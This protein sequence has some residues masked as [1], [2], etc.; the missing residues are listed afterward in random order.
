MKNIKIKKAMLQGHSLS[1]EYE[2]II[3]DGTAPV[4]NLHKS[5]MGMLCHEDLVHAFNRLKF[6]FALLC[7]F[8]EV[9]AVEEQILDLDRFDFG[10]SLD[11]VF[12]T[13][14]HIS[15]AMDHDTLTIIG[16]KTLPKCRCIHLSAPSVSDTETEYHYTSEL[17]EVLENLRVEIYS[18]LF[19]G[20]CAVKQMEMDFDS[21]EEV[22]VEAGGNEIAE[23]KAEE[24]SEVS[25]RCRK[26][27]KSLSVT[28][29][30]LAS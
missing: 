29:G 25:R 9:A 18:Y 16:G 24:P 10:E 27:K 20:K 7:D 3:N 2:E 1:V 26:G 4:T 12:I 28:V 5:N 8:K 30:V 22:S 13:G 11:K 21:A 17:F 15:Y 19:E 23:E 6:H 14:I